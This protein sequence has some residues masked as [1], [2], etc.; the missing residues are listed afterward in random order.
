MA[1]ILNEFQVSVGDGNLAPETTPLHSVK[2]NQVSSKI[3]QNK[4][5]DKNLL[6]IS[7]SL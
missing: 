5:K 4:K 3:A 6:K 1:I 2:P 7:N